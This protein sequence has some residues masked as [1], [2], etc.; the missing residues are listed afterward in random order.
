MDSLIMLLS[1]FA[2][3][4]VLFC[5]A[6]LLALLKSTSHII[7]ANKQL[8]IVVAGKEAKPEALRALVASSKPPQSKLRGVATGKKKNEKK[9][10]NTDYVLNIGESDAL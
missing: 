5:I 4:L 8:L 1:I 9:P 10:A 2:G 7:E 6:L 3:I